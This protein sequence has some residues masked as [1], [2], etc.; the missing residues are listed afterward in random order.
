MSTD[1]ALLTNWQ[2]QGD[3]LVQTDSSHVPH[4]LL[5]G[6]ALR[7]FEFGAAMRLKHAANNEYPTFGILAQYN[8][9]ERLIIRFLQQEERWVLAI[10]SEGMKPAVN[11]VLALSETFDPGALHRLNIIQHRC[12]THILLDDNEVLVVVYTTQ[13]S[14]PGLMTQHA[15]VEF[16]HIWQVGLE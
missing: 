8:E 1:Q 13:A 6:T 16:T 4:T 14:Q 5:Q 12:Q 15:S 3:T 7:D 11:R 2:Q 10:E 9:E